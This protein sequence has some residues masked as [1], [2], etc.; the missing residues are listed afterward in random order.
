LRKLSSKLTF[1]ADDDELLR[2]FRALK[3]R[4]DVAGLLEIPDRTLTYYAYRNR[5]Y[6]TFSIPKRRGGTRTISAPAN[7][8]KILQQ[9]LNHVFRLVYKTKN[10]V[11]GFAVGKDIVTNAALHTKRR[12]VLNIDLKDFFHSINFGRVRGMLMA[13]P[14]FVGSGAATVLAQVC[15]FDGKLPQGAPTSPMVT[16]MVCGRLDSEL[17]KLAFSHR[18]NY[19]RYA[20]DITISSSR[21]SFPHSLAE[22]KGA[23]GSAAVGIE[24]MKA[25]KSNGFEV[26]PDKVR[27]QL[28]NERQEVTGLVCNKFPNVP[29][30]Y[31]RQLRGTLHAWKKFGG[32]AAAAHFFA[33]YYHKRPGIG[34]VEVFK[35][36]IRGRIE[37][38]GH[39]RGKDDPIYRKSLLQF[40]ELNPECRIE[41]GDDIDT[42]FRVIKRA[43]WVIE[44]DST[45]GTAF[46]VERY[47]LV[48]CSHVVGENAFIFS[49]EEPTT[50]YRVTKVARA[51][52]A[53]VACLE[54]KDMPK[55]KELKVGDSNRLRTQDPVTLLGF[56]EYG[57]GDKS[58][59]HRGHVTGKRTHFGYER[60]LISPTIVAGNS[61]GPV[62]DSRN[63]VVGIAA[64]GKD[65][66]ASTTETQYGVIPVEVLEMLLAQ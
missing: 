7:N 20:D 51:D 35:R 1:A 42:D 59:V 6:K 27:L 61:G 25:I 4:R 23:P 33:N 56:P 41:I 12:F 57:K 17:K 22:H 11:H 5:S 28:F 47:G 65:N 15:T 48:T 19:T 8:L 21:R 64:T 54:A 30:A 13:R 37:F 31:I 26:N 38:V 43:L 40:G 34:D 3:S 24:L 9:K 18:C 2:R 63:R 50:R 10:V 39:V 66:S 29:R 36:V 60:I 52:D 62:L 49:A 55:L 45:Q 44:S 32:L 46:V 53:D 16:N 14:Y 58:I